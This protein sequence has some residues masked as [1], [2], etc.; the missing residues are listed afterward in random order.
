MAH[1]DGNRQ[2]AAGVEDLAM[3][4]QR[5][6][7]YEKPE[8]KIPA[9]GAAIAKELTALADRCRKAGLHFSAKLIDMAVFSLRHPN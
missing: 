6:L 3:S 7:L 5:E 9:A 2:L 8:I 4:L 1:D